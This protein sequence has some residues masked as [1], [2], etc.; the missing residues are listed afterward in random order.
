MPVPRLFEAA[1]EQAEHWAHSLACLVELG[2]PTTRAAIIT[3]LVGET[4]VDT[5]TA[6][7]RERRVLGGV[8]ADL[9]IRDQDRRWA[10]AV[11]STLGF[12][13][14]VEAVAD[15]LYDSLTPDGRAIV[16]IITP[17]R[18]VP[19]AIEKARASGREVH[20]KSWLRVRD[21][22][23]ERPERGKA[24]GLDLFLLTE[25]EYFLTP[26]VAELYRLEALM[27]NV[28]ENLRPTL[29]SLYFDM[30]DL[31]PAPLIERTDHIVFPRTGDAKVDIALKDCGI[32]VTLSTSV[33][34]PGFAA[35]GGKATLRVT[36]PANYLAARSFVRATARDLLP[37]RR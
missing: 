24:E 36:D 25:A 5:D 35:D 11:W 23:Q 32:D 8:D 10:V 9:L 19:D 30:N 27:P 34:G 12:G 33:T 14:D 18:R 6:M 15:A 22:V 16:V 17:D 2:S 1:S 28:A 13:T 7:V 4:L 31:S 37:P 21:W 3:E 29:G 26:R 20:H